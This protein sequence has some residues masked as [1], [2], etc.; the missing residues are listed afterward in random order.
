M[1]PVT[2]AA[3]QTDTQRIERA[4]EVWL[5]TG[6]PLS[7]RSGGQWRSVLADLTPLH[8]LAGCRRPRP[9]CICAARNGLNCHVCAGLLVSGGLR[10]HYPLHPDLPS[11]ACGGYRQ[12]LDVLEQARRARR[13]S[14]AFCHR[15]LA[16]RPS[17]GCAVPRRWGRIA[18]P[19][20]LPK[21]QALR[22]KAGGA[23]SGHGTP[24]MTGGDSLTSTWNA[25]CASPA[26]PRRSGLQGVF[27]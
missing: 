26:P 12:V 3:P 2:A 20:A 23:P 15:Q 16:K 6:K 5:L 7:S 19:D 10:S 27:P 8:H 13:R 21:A 17:P 9:G 24:G 11:C 14:I 22:C 4:L 25:R 1:D 18:M